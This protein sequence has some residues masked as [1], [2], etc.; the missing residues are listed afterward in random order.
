VRDLPHHRPVRGVTP[1]ARL[2]DRVGRWVIMTGGIGVIAAVLGI[3]VFILR[4]SYPLFQDP[5]VS[6]EARI[7]VSDL[8]TALAIGSDPY[9]EIVYAVHAEGVTFVDVD[10]K[11][12]PKTERPDVLGDAEITS[13]HRSVRGDFIGLGTSDGRVLGVRVVFDVSFSAA[14]RKIVPRVEVVDNHAVASTGSVLEVAYRNDGKG[15]SLAL[16]LLDDG[17]LICSIG[18]RSRS[19]IGGGRFNARRFDLSEEVD[20]PVSSLGSDGRKSIL[21]GLKD[22]RILR[23]RLQKDTRP[24]LEET[25]HTS[26]E[27]D[28]VTEMAFLLGDE[29]LITG[30]SL[31]RVDAWIP[32]RGHG[33]SRPVSYRRVHS[34]DPMPAAVRAIAPSARDKQFVT[35]DASGHVSLHHA[36]SDQTFLTRKSFE[37]GLDALTIAPKADGIIGASRGSVL[38]SSLY[39]PHPEITLKTLFGAVWYEGYPG[40]EHAWQSSGGSDEFEPKL[41]LVPLLFG[42]AKGTLYAMLF[43]LPLAL[44]AAV[45]TSEFLRPEVRSVVKPTVELM[46]S[47]PSVILGFLAG[48]WLAPLLHERV[49][50]VLLLFPLVPAIVVLASWTW[51]Q[52]PRRIA[53][54]L[55]ERTEIILLVPVTLMGGWLAFELGP[56][57][58]THLMGGSFREWLLSSTGTRYDQRNCLVVGFAMG[59]AVIPIIYT[60]CEDALSSVPGHLRAGSLALGATLWQTAIRVVLPTASPGIFSATMIGFGRAIGE[61]M[62]VLMA[63]GNTPILDW[64]IFN[65]MRTMSANIAVEIPEAPHEGTL[66][67]VLFLT[68]LLLSLLTFL[69]NTVA[70]IVRQRL[71]E[72]YSRI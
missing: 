10:H 27:G 63:T 72:R 32:V 1:A 24:M 36:T 20:T 14:G 12:T 39:N 38:V 53:V 67:R 58:E 7:D 6:E 61:T 4:E 25:I 11:W 68:G 41:G 51:R 65:G 5:V 55:P 54:W 29:T 13:A 37:T 23:W 2:A 3:F 52:M 33:P 18:S 66:Y 34:L 56:F 30:T 46:A 60:I 50:G 62:I 48:L 43:A 71:R 59:F 28:A 49:V 42:T 44:L 40:P 35:G 22:G 69:L 9:M 21:A 26:I 17:S 15:R 57:V 45:Y 8:P 64:S 47:L 19:L 31:G 70:E 16:A